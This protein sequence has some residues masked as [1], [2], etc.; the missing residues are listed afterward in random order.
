MKDFLPLGGVRL[1][2]PLDP[3]LRGHEYRL[4]LREALLVGIGEIAEYRELN[5]G[6]TVRQELTFQMVKRLDH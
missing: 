5:G 4:I 3:P 1:V 2:Q 6:V